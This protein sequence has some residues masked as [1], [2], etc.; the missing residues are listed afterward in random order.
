MEHVRKVAV[1]IYS[2]KRLVELQHQIYTM[3]N[4]DEVPE[5]IFVAVKGFS[6]YH[7]NLFLKKKF[8]RFNSVVIKCVTNKNQLS[9][10]LDCV[11]GEDLGLFDYFLKVDDDDFYP[12]DYVAR[13]KRLMNRKL[14]KNPDL[15]GHAFARV[16]NLRRQEGSLVFNEVQPGYC[17]GGTLGF[18]REVLDFLFQV[19]RNPAVL[20]D[21]TGSGSV[22]EDQ[23]I[24]IL[25]RRMGGM[26]VHRDLE[27]YVYNEGTASVMR[28]RDNYMGIQKA[29]FISSDY[30][31]REEES[32]L[33]LTHP[34]WKRMFRLKGGVLT[35]LND[36]EAPLD[37]TLDRGI[38]QIK[39]RRWGRE[40]FIKQADGSFK[41]HPPDC[42]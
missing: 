8:S 17:F 21:V 25:M 34:S 41:F 29:V 28:N 19:E 9:N 36:P 35:D 4:Q 18:R 23:L 33:F 13:V 6:E 26:Y 20:Q 15:M 27:E 42:L 11:R 30:I 14:V 40:F 31:Q 3:L 2:Y 24:Q 22:A 37:F 16:H 7:V 38:L 32:F 10:L 1:L 39:W 5:R 12:A